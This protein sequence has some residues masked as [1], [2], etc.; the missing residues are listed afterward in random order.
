MTAT[1]VWPLERKPRRDDALVVE[2]D[3]LD[4]AGDGVA[5]LS[6]RISGEPRKLRVLAPGTLPGEVVT[7][8]VLAVHRND[9]ECEVTSL[10]AATAGAARRVPPCPVALDISAP[11]SGPACGGCALQHTALEAQEAEKQRR[12]A[13]LLRAGERLRPLVGSPEGLGYRNKLELSCGP[14]VNEGHLALGLHPRGYR[15]ELISLPA[16]RLMAEGSARLIP[17]LGEWLRVRGFEAA[18]RDGDGGLLRTVTLR[19]TSTGERLVD[20]GTTDAPTAMLDGASVASD[21]A[22]AAF[23]E[24][25]VALGEALS[26][27]LTGVVWTRRRAARG[28]R[29]ELDT[30]TLFGRASITE[31]LA[32]PGG[33]LFLELGPRTFFQPN[34]RAAERLYSLILEAACDEGTPR[35]ALDLYCGVGGIALALARRCEAVLGIELVPESV[36]AAAEN[37]RRNGLTNVTFEV[38]DA[39]AV[40]RERGLAPDV[41]VVDPPRAGLGVALD[42]VVAL[43]AARLVYVSCNPESLARELPPLRRA[44]Y[45]LIWAQGV[46]QFPHTP[47]VE[48]VARLDRAPLPLPT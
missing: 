30:C 33:P 35:L 17:A 39:G 25:A 47:H 21:V 32:L 8:R 42:A 9:V 20:L 11:R 1:R 16:C 10:D 13:Q 4:S 18:R 3:H 41:V 22:A 45:E 34:T 5:T 19:E 38:G 23:A 12:L 28:R 15:H 24:A 29:T 44:G 27:P 14:A 2:I 37:A 48:V 26:A 31:R 7:L 43:G 36:A 6:A 40:L 46:D